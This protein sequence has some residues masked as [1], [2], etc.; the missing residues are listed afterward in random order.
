MAYINLLEAQQLRAISR[1]TTAN[2]QALT[3]LTASFATSGAGLRS[4]ADRTRTE[5]LIQEVEDVRADE[6]VQLASARL[7]QTGARP[8]E[9]LARRGPDVPYPRGR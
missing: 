3:D 1:E 2:L 9:I 4:D 6:N 5:L 8:T 7:A